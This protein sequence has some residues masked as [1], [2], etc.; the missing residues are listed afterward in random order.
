MNKNIINLLIGVSKYAVGF[1]LTLVFRLLSPFLG[2]WNVSPLMATELTGAKVY[3]PFVGGLYGALSILLLDIL[4]GRVGMWT[5]ITAI[6]YGFVGIWGAFYL[7]ERSASAI[8]FV[9]ASILGTLFFYVITGVLMG[10]LLYGQSW[11][12]AIIGQVPFTLRHLAGNMVFAIVLAP[13]FYKQIM[14][15]KIWNTVYYKLNK[16]SSTN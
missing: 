10:P 6:T 12:S 2:L 11:T 3:G 1:I 13:W 15:S 4:V 14:T 16:E 9:V 5:V 7:K 8:N